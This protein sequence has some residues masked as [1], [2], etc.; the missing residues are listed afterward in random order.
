MKLLL[1]VG[2]RASGKGAFQEVAEELGI[3]CYEMS[4]VIFEWMEEEGV[5][6][7]NEN[8]ASFSLKV[9]EMHG[10]DIVAR[11]LSERLEGRF[12]VVS[13]I[14]SKEEVEFFRQAHEALVLEIKAEESV[15]FRRLASRKRA[16]DP[17]TWE[18]FLKREEA[19]DA[20]GLKEALSTADVC[21]ENNG[22]LEEF[23][24]KAERFLRFT[25]SS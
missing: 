4:S 14:R 12:A 19:E 23:K 24:E 13:G 6:V 5:E 11:K 7:N 2:R 20:L 21:I 16:Q 9:R 15:R 18:E 10:K 3:P 8:T 25:F 17:K 22:T 1:V